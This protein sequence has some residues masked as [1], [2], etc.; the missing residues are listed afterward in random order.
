MNVQLTVVV[1]VPAD[2]RKVPALVNVADA[3]L[4]RV[5]E[6]SFRASKTA[7]SW[8]VQLPPVVPRMSAALPV[9]VAVLLF[10]RVT[11][12][13]TSKVNEELPDLSML[14][15]PLSVRDPLPDTEP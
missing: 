7:P 3:P 14:A 2:L 8:V 1:P 13:P 5:M 12:R 9:Q 6:R 10:A 4:A 15:P 11:A